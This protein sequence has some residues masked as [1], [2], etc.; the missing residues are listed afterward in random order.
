[1]QRRAVLRGGFAA[2]ILAGLPACDGGGTGDTGTTTGTPDTRDVDVPQLSIE[3]L[4][5]A[6]ARALADSP[7]ADD[8]AELPELSQT[9]IDAIA[10]DFPAAATLMARSIN[11]LAGPLAGFAGDMREAAASGA[12][13]EDDFVA[14]LRGLSDGVMATYKD[15]K[16]DIDAYL[17][18]AQAA[19]LT[20]QAAALDYTEQIETIRAY[21]VEARQYIAEGGFADHPGANTVLMGMTSLARVHHDK[22][23]DDVV[24][25][26]QLS[27]AVFEQTYD[28]GGPNGPPPP[29]GTTD[30]WLD[31]LR[32]NPV[33]WIGSA[34]GA[35]VGIVG[36]WGYFTALFGSVAALAT[37]GLMGALWGLL[38]ALIIIVLLYAILV[39]VVLW[40]SEITRCFE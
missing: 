24:G 27:L 1:M 29:P 13:T 35:W 10:P 32:C 30:E 25:N 26:I 28:S 17:I 2:S 40:I 7:W 14:E 9:L 33:W 3:T 16:G 34:A 38:A 22:D 5:E 4:S 11:E 23:F 37:V 31:K 21:E 20:G 12:L 39:I 18:E 36:L 6:I 19:D 8:F 15:M